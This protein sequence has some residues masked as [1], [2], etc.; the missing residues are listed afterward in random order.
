MRGVVDGQ[1]SVED[2]A[3]RLAEAI[4]SETFA[5]FDSQVDLDRDRRCGFPEV[6][7]SEGKTVEAVVAILE[8]LSTHGQAALATRVSPEQAVAV[9]GRFPAAIYNPFRGR[10][11]WQEPKKSR[12]SAQWCS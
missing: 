3:G 4:Q 5:T 10:F 12:R 2:A 11:G 1:M 6:V 9:G 8:A 7:Y